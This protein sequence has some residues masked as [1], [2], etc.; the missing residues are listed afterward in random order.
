VAQSSVESFRFRQVLTRRGIR[1]GLLVTVLGIIVTGTPT[2]G[3]VP[4]ARAAQAATFC[5]PVSGISDVALND[6]GDRLYVASY[7]PDLSAVSIIDTASDRILGAIAPPR[8]GSPGSPLHLVLRGA[9]I[10]A[11]DDALHRIVKIDGRNDK[12]AAIFDLTPWRGSP[13]FDPTGGK[14]YFA[15]D[16]TV[17]LGDRPPSVSVLDLKTGAI[18]SEIKLVAAPAE[19]RLSTDGGKLYVA[20]PGPMVT[21]IDTAS[22]AAIGM[23]PVAVGSASELFAL[24]PNGMKAYVKGWPGASPVSLVDIDAGKATVTLPDFSGD[25]DDIVFSSDGRTAYFANPLARTGR[26]TA[27]RHEPGRNVA[28]VDVATNRVKKNILAGRGPIRPSFSRDGAQLYVEN[29]AAASISIID[30]ATDRVTMTIPVGRWPAGVFPNHAG[31]T[32]YVPNSWDD[33]VS[34]IDLKTDHVVA[35]IPVGH[36]PSRVLI[37]PDDRQAYVANQRPNSISVIDASRNERVATLL[38]P[39]AT[40]AGPSCA[41]PARPLGPASSPRAGL[42]R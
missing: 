16:N 25:D 32:G 10:Y 34:V 28:V 18:M 17:T 31:T 42:V 29:S 7:D 19:V 11:V 9:D 26:P 35:T 14:A 4:V 6:A 27:G 41:V 30:I 33:T 21:V 20:T 38:M 37:T 39:R 22:A 24:A 1:K 3:S 36:A 8:S 40:E 13:A 23:I 2:G 12:L 5:D 15:T